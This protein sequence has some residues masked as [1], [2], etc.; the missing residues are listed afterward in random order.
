MQSGAKSP[1]KNK[2]FCLTIL[3]VSIMKQ[4]KTRRAN[5][6]FTLA[7]LLVVLLSNVYVGKAQTTQSDT[8][9]SKY[10]GSEVKAVKFSPDG[11]FIYAAAIGRKPMKLSTETS[12]I[13]KEYDNTLT[14][15]YSIELS[16]DGKQLIVGGIENKIQKINTDDGIIIMNYNYPQSVIENF[17]SYFAV[18]ISI[19]NDESQVAALTRGITKEGDNIRVVLIWD[20][21]TG[22]II[23]EIYDKNAQ[24]IKFSPTENLLCIAH[25]N[26]ENNPISV[27]NTLTWKD[28]IPLGYHS[29][30]IEDITFSPDGSLLASC[31]WDGF[32]K[33]WDVKER[34]L[35]RES[36]KFKR[37]KSVIFISNEYI[38]GG[39]NDDL[40][41]DLYVWNLNNNNQF[42][43]IPLS[44]PND[45]NYNEINKEIVIGDF[46]SVTLLNWDKILDIKE[47]PKLIN[48]VLIYPN[49]TSGI[50]NI[51]IDCQT[52]SKYEIFNT[53]GKLIKSKEIATELNNFLI[54]D[55]TQYD[56][57]VYFV[58]VHC[59]NVVLNFQVV[60][61]E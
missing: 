36:N 42:T 59:L 35:V 55:F 47:L 16:K 19:S 23:K 22:K 46:E 38:I 17:Y 20:N 28:E 45:L 39:S 13:I 51:P 6:L 27:L 40:S 2:Q 33:I 25:A 18:S 60:K 29:I 54:I 4:Q 37:F 10:I 8:V 24:N 21:H 57:G 31:G 41:S 48:S 7:A 43:S 52:A 44:R 34:K 61:G 14:N 11:Q 5:T 56:K 58:N 26:L 3:G 53:S 9:W 12:E 32:I 50:V 1:V 49:P 15:C 30:S